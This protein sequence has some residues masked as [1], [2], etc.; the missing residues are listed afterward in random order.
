[1]T[2]DKRIIIEHEILD[3][4]DKKEGRI[5]QTELSVSLRVSIGLINSYLKRLVQ[6]GFIKVSNVRASTVRYMLTPEGFAE[7]YR[8]VRRYMTNNLDY[9]LKIKKTVEERILRLK[10][11]EVRTVV[12]VGSS[13]IAEIMHLYLTDTKIKILSVFDFEDNKKTFFKYPVL[14]V[15][16][17]PEYLKSNQVDKILLNYFD[18]IEEIEKKLINL[19]IKKDII[20]SKW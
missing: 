4:I 7:K 12:F 19:G 16:K 5:T 6:K 20:E 9:Y 10:I 14:D 11:D 17:L 3:A 2:E 13:E 15:K 1:M 18:N 8:L